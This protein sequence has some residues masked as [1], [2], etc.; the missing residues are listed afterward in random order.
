MLRLKIKIQSDKENVE[1]DFL[2]LRRM[3]WGLLNVLILKKIWFAYFTNFWKIVC[4]PS[5]LSGL[6][7]LKV[8]LPEINPFQIEV[9]V[10]TRIQE[11]CPPFCTLWTSCFDKPNGHN[12]AAS[13]HGH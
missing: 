10:W 13:M 11:E 4:F 5:L 6:S 3:I 7:L 8:L 1:L 2:S 9:G 12:Y